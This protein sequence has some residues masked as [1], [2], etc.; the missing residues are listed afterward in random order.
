MKI[1]MRTLE[2]VHEK[3]SLQNYNVIVIEVLE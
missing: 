2:A 1:S 3:K